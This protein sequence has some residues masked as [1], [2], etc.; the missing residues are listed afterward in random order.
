MVLQAKQTTFYA[1]CPSLETA[2]SH[3]H[4]PAKIKVL[5]SDCLE[6]GLDLKRKGFN[7]VVLNMACATCPG[8]VF[9]NS[10][11]FFQGGGYKSGAGAQEEDLFRRSNYVQSLEDPDHLDSERSWKYPIPEFG[12]V[13]SPSVFVFRSGGPSGF[14][15]FIV[16]RLIGE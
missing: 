1:E 14:V 6:V 8:T 3:S 15:L 2:S 7:P 5:N 11:S 9:R 13:Y 16:L 4:E 10:N 12:G